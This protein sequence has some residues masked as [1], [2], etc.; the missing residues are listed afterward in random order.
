MTA[1]PRPRGITALSIF[2]AFGAAMSFTAAVALLLPGGFLD[3]MWSFNPRAREGFA[4]I[5]SWAILLMFALCAACIFSAIG[6]W[7]GRRWGHRSA[8]AVLSINVLGD[9]ANGVFGADPRALIGVPIGFALL[10]YLGT[11]RVRSFVD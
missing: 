4:S 9:I 7:R 2:F 10:A 3:P 6:L 1:Q 11:R 5:G 8:T